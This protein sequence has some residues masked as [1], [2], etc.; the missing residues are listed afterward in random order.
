MKRMNEIET[1]DVKVIPSGTIVSGTMTYE[2]HKLGSM[3][4]VLVNSSIR[5]DKGGNG[6]A[7]IIKGLMANHGTWISGNTVSSLIAGVVGGNP[8]SG[9]AILY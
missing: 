9:V 6:W 8:S 3:Y 1:N 4:I 5:W 2:A 7:F